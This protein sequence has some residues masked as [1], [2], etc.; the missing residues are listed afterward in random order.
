MSLP[1]WLVKNQVNGFDGQWKLDT[2]RY[3]Q[4]KS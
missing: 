2:W 4:Q 1:D 3:I